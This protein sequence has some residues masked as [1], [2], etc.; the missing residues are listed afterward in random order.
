MIIVGTKKT[1]EEKQLAAKELLKKMK[2]DNKDL[3]A[4]IADFVALL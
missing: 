3:F 1:K 2:D 4:E